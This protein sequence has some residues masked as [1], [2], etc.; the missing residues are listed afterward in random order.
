[1]TQLVGFSISLFLTCV[2]PENTHPTPP[3]KAQPFENPNNVSYISLNALVLENP[4]EYKY[5]LELHNNCISF[6]QIIQFVY[7]EES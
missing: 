1:M 5:F 3:Q 7:M 4:Q 2:V 6:M